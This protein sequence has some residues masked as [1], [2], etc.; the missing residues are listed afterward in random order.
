MV[1]NY[2]KENGIHIVKEVLEDLKNK[3]NWL[4]SIK[5]YQLK[6]ERIDKKWG[7]LMILINKE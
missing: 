7:V 1:Q 4:K 5:D 2:G 6:Q 3:L